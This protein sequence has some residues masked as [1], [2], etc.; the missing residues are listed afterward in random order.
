M[1]Y[2]KSIS[3]FVCGVSLY[4]G[5]NQEDQGSLSAFYRENGDRKAERIEQSKEEYVLIFQPA[6]IH[7]EEEPDLTDINGRILDIAG[8]FK[9]LNNELARAAENADVI[10]R[11][12][13]KA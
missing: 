2:V 13:G 12:H 10:G 8:D 5:R 4:N 7:P 1:P 11:R 6:N 3:I 9:A